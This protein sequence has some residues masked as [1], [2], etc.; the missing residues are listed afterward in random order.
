VYDF[1]N[2]GM[3]LAAVAGSSTST[4]DWW[5]PPGQMA[6]RCTPT[7]TFKFET[8]RLIPKGPGK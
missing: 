8:Q 2:A 7:E 3:W 5:A 4:K 6:G 1:G